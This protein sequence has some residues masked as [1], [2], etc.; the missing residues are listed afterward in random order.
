MWS[1]LATDIMRVVKRA[2]WNVVDQVLSALSNV[3]LSVLV[4]RTVDAGGFGAFSTAFLIFSAVIAFT[5]AVVGQ[6]MQIT[7]ASA[8]SGELTAAVRHALGAAILVGMLSGVIVI[9]TG[10]ALPNQTGNALITL[11]LCLPGLLLQDTCRICFFCSG[12]PH[13]AA[14]VD[15]LWFVTEFGALALVLVAGVHAVWPPIA[16]WGASAAISGAIGVRM[17]K[18][19]PRFSGAVRWALDQRRLTGYLLAEYIIGQGLI[20]VGIL[21][22]AVLGTSEGVGALRAAQVLLG[23]L[24]ILVSAVFMFAVPEVSRRP[25]MSWRWRKRL[26]FGVAS[27]MGLVTGLFC[28][29]LLLIP[30]SLGNRLLGDTWRGAASVL[31]PMC[32]LSLSASVATGPAA[33]LYGMGKARTT[34]GIN[35]VRAPLLIVFMSVGIKLHGAVGAAWALA[36]TETVTLPAWFLRVRQAARAASPSPGASEL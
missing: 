2:G 19:L 11:G 36:A 4:A 13:L 10:F 16:V 33:I 9:A 22:V 28:G 14:A 26:S 32:V 6:P 29:L 34:F 8:G 5:R 15:A 24:S 3:L 20:Q 12:R 35:I 30:D 31:I 27:G 18:A 17:L 25:A 7:F 1:F 21:L 23:P